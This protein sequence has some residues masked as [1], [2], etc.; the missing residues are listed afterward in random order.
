MS[1]GAV[2]SSLKRLREGHPQHFHVLLIALWV[3]IRLR[4][5]AGEEHVRATGQERGSMNDPQRDVFRCDQSCLF[6][7]LASRAIQRILIAVEGAGRDFPRGCVPR[8]APLPNQHGVRVLEVRD[9]ERRVRVDKHRVA[10]LGSVRKTNDVVPQGEWARRSSCG[11]GHNFERP[12][13][14]RMLQLAQ[15]FCTTTATAAAAAARWRG[16]AP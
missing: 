12:A 11:R 15:C 13:A 7:Q 10:R 3:P 6:G 5:R 14:G 16:S 8:V 2:E 9:Y 4:D 1:D